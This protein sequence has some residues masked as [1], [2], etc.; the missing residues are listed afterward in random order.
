MSHSFFLAILLI[1]G[2]VIDAAHGTFQHSELEAYII[3]RYTVPNEPADV[4]GL[5]PTQRFAAAGQV[6]IQELSPEHCWAFALPDGLY[7]FGR[8]VKPL[9]QQDLPYGV[10]NLVHG[11]LDD[12]DVLD[13]LVFTS[14][15][16]SDSLRC[17]TFY[18]RRLGV[19]SAKLSDDDAYGVRVFGTGFTCNRPG[20]GVASYWKEA[21][22][23]WG[24]E[25]HFK[26][27][28]VFQLDGVRYLL[29]TNTSCA[30]ECMDFD[31]YRFAEDL[32]DPIARVRLWSY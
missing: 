9:G 3:S 1:I 30:G 2:S 32:S 15:A 13:A 26:I 31:L 17:A 28:D 18:I 5:L 27:W 25:R 22:V 4:G 11:H 21:T 12:A 29:V 8:E 16:H 19:P 23:R 14:F 7:C 24:E 10:L 20:W 6:Q